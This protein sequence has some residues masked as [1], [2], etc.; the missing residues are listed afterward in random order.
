MQ[1]KQMLTLSQEDVYA[2]ALWQ[3]EMKEKYFCLSIFKSLPAKHEKSTF[4]AV[5]QDK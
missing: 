3:L 5:L 1:L 4:K 2:E